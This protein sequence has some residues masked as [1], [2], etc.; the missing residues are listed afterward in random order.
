MKLTRLTSALWNPTDAERG[1][2]WGLIVGTIYICLTRGED[3]SLLQTFKAG[4]VP[5]SPL[6]VV[7]NPFFGNDWA[8]RI[9]TMAFLFAAQAFM[10]YFFVRKKRITKLLFYA[11]WMTDLIWIA[12]SIQQNIT[13]IA[14]APLIMVYPWFVIFPILQKLPVGWSLNLTDPHW[15]CAFGTA[16]RTPECTNVAGRLL[17][18]GSGNFIGAA[19]LILAFWVVFPLVLWWLRRRKEKLRGEGGGT[20]ANECKCRCCPECD[21]CECWNCRECKSWIGT[22]CCKI[23]ESRRP[24]GVEKN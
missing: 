2:L 1:I 22:P 6:W 23:G 3:W 8:Y 12:N 16:I 14:L 11:A 15:T 19:N 9:Y 21:W 17:Y 5:Y 7:L 20:S 4:D 18:I 10:W 13:V 24:F